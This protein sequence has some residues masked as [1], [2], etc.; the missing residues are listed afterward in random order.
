[1][2]FGQ[3]YSSGLHDNHY[4]KNLQND[5]QETSRHFIS[6]YFFFFFFY[7]AFFSGVKSTILS[8]SS[9]SIVLFLFLFF[10]FFFFFVFFSTLFFF[11]FPPLF[12]NNLSS[13]LWKKGRTK[14]FFFLIARFRHTTGVLSRVDE[15]FLSR[16]KKKK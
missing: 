8:F 14:T 4:N 12:E 2:K 16:G 9:S 6:T 15:K 10:F 11:F 7:P 13:D 5:Y 3:G 1:M